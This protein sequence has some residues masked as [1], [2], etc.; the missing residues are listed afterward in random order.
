[1][2]GKGLSPGRDVGFWRFGDVFASL[3]LFLFAI[4]FF[5][6]FFLIYFFFSGGY[7]EKETGVPHPD[8]R[9]LLR[10]GNVRLELGSE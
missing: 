1:M 3:Y 4:F 10:R 5:F 7:G 6:F 8:D 9:T 2:V